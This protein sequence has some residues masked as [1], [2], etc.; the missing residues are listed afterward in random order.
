MLRNGEETIAILQ[1]AIS[2][3]K[4]LSDQSINVAIEAYEAGQLVG[5][6]DAATHA[7]GIL[8]GVCD[9]IGDSDEPK[10]FELSLRS[11]PRQMLVAIKL[12]KEL[13]LM[14]EL[15]AAS[16]QMIRKDIKDEQAT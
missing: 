14:D 11:M 9:A 3:L 16:V 12:A 1:F 6:P 13:G 7:I 10:L 2:K 8:A 15:R 5:S 4:P